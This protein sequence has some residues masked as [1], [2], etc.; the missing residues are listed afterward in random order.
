MGLYTFSVYPPHLF[1]TCGH[2][3]LLPTHCHRRRLVCRWISIPVGIVS[4]WLYTHCHR[5]RLVCSGG[6]VDV[7][8]Y[9]D[10]SIV[11]THFSPGFT[12][13]G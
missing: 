10:T 8:I 2:S 4:S 6:N 7:C 12:A 11:E 9:M 1:Y 3:F 5:K 13:V